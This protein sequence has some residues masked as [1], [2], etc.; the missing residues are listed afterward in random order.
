MKRERQENYVNCRKLLHAMHNFTNEVGLV[1]H[2]IEL[3]KDKKKRNK[4]KV[5][6]DNADA[7][8]VNKAERDGRNMTGRVLGPATEGL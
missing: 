1:G 5:I 6:R 2:E 3:I 4:G 8:N 7:G